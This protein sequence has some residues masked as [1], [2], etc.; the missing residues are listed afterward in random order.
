VHSVVFGNPAPDLI[1]YR[2][3]QYPEYHVPEPFLQLSVLE[4][5]VLGALIEKEVTT[6]DQY[7]LSI[8]SLKLAC[9][10]KSNRD[11]FM[12]TDESAVQETVNGLMRQFLIAEASGNR[13]PRYRQSLC[14]DEHA[15]FIV[16]PQERAL[17]CELLLRGP[18]TAGELRSR[19]QRMAPFPALADVETVLQLLLTREGQALVTQ[20]PRVPGS[21]E[22]R[23]AQL[24]IPA[25]QQSIAPAHPAALAVST[26]GND[27]EGRIAALESAVAALQ[28]EVDQLR[29]ELRPRIAPPE[30]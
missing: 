14:G 10:Q 7:P 26:P 23:Y 19:A 9:N 29:P 16:S 8:N 24:L 2:R 15:R 5:R 18:Q 12:E 27:Y 25:P 3:W 11:P 21:R 17:L 6:P 30:G 4:A 22:V 20:L 28:V 13:V 1:H